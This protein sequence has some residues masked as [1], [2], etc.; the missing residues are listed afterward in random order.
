MYSKRLSGNFNLYQS[1]VVFFAVRNNEL[2]HQSFIYER[3]VNIAFSFMAKTREMGEHSDG[4]K[5]KLQK[6]TNLI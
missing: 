4:I 3:V 1:Q 6:I 5:D 2:D